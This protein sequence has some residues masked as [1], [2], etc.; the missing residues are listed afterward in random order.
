[1]PKAPASSASA[2][3]ACCAP[4]RRGQ[5]PAV[6]ARQGPGLGHRRIWHAPARHPHARQPRGGQGQAVRPHAGNPAADRPLAAR[7][8]RP[9]KARRAPDHRRLRRH[10]GRRRHAHRGDFRRLGRASHR[11]RQAARKPRRSPTDP[12]R[13][14]VAAVS[15]G[16]HNGT[17]VL[18]LD[19]DEDSHGRL[20]RQFRAHRRRRDRR[21]A[22]H[23]RG[24]MLRRGRAAAAAPPRPHRLRARFSRRSCKATGR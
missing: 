1:M 18:D 2:T 7:R 24:R 4:P 15:C 10:P 12:I 17:A 13:T 8:G 19:Y 22:G 9:A 16:I 6:P 3:R 20:R 11:G 21:G 23:R 5:G 14:Q